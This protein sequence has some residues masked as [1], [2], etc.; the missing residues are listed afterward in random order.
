MHYLLEVCGQAW[1]DTLRVQAMKRI[2]DQPRAWFDSE[3]TSSLV[4]SLDRNAEEMRNL[5][6][7]FAAFVFVAVIMLIIAIVWS[8]VLC[9]KLTLVA[10][11]CAPAVY[12][13]TQLF[14]TLSGKWEGKS[15]DA[16]A[17]AS[18]IFTETFGAIRTVRSMTLEGYFHEKYIKATDGALRAGM[19]RSGFSGVLFGI[20]ESGIVFITGKSLIHPFFLIIENP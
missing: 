8:L 20:S 17:V 1:I 6:G 12:A 16:G 2:L 5:L 10:L 11:A 18:S 14:E 9:W 13:V 3:E 19:K 7:R 15:N 4:E